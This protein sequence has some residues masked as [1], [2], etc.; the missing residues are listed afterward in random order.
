[1]GWTETY[2]PKGQKLLD[3]FVEHGTLR[4]SSPES[5]ID[6]RV[7]DSAFVNCSEFYAAVEFIDKLTGKRDVWCAT[8]MVKLYKEKNGY[9]ICYKDMEES[10]GPCMYNCPE[11]ILDLLTPTDNENV[12]VWRAQNREKI[13]K[14]KTK[15][16]LVAGTV[17]LADPP[18]SFTDGSQQSRLTVR[19]RRGSRVN[20]VEGYRLSLQYINR[21]FAN[22]RISFAPAT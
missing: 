15:P 8:F 18:I 10:M 20:F 16:P 4:W 1:M 5:K 19:D 14:R 6:A 2:K 22:Q 21:A 9:N 7:L 12:N 13:V 11:R 17:L 3:F